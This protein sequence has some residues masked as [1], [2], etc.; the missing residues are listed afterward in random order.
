MILTALLAVLHAHATGQS[1]SLLE[2]GF[3]R[4][5]DSVKPSVYWYWMS[6]NISD[7]GVVKDLEAM[8][9]I[10]IGRAFIGN[11]GMDA[12]E[13]TYGDVKMFS[14]DWWRITQLA[15][16][17]AGRLGIDIGLFNSPGWS[18]S[19]GPWVQPRQA[20]R[21]L[22]P[23]VQR[24]KGPQRF[25]SRLSAP[26][27]HFQDVAV[28]A[29]P[30]EENQVAGAITA[31]INIPDIRHMT[32]GDTAS[33]AFLP[34]GTKA[35]ILDLS[36]P[37]AITA[38]S[39][40]L[41]PARSP[42]SARCELQVLD[43][44]RYRSVQ[45]FDADRSNPQ[46]SVGFMPYGPVAISFPAVSGTAFRL[47]FTGVRGKMGFAEITLGTA[48]K[49]ERYI[50]KQLAKMFQTPLPLWNEYQWAPAP[51]PNAPVTPA[52]KVVDLSRL[53]RPD[54]SLQ[55]NVP[56]GTWDVIRFG[57][58][59]TGVNNSPAVP[60]GT[61][62]EVDKMNK[63]ALAAHFN[64]FVGKIQQ[65]M[66][67][68][69]RSA[70]K[71]VVADSYETGSQNWT[72][73][74]A[75]AF[76]KKYGYDPLPWLPVLTGRIIGSAD[77]SD[78]FLW[79]LRRMVADR[80][81]YDYV[82]G[83]RELSHR[84]GLRVWLEN[85]GHWG[86]PGEF[87]QYGGQS[88]EVGGEF[89]NEGDLGSI[90]NKAAS[91]AAH[92]YGK[93]R[94]AAESFT[95]G[96]RPYQR[97]PALLKKRGDWSF[98]EGVNHTLLHVYIQQP[99][100]ERNPGV[101]AWFG[102]EFNRKNTW[103]YQSKAFIDYIRRCNF[104][105]QQ[106]LPVNDVA[107]FIGEDAPK[108]T[109][110]RD[111]ALPAGY[112]F[113][114]INAEVIQHRLQVKNGRFVLPD[115]M[116]YRL[117]VLPKLATMRPALL[118]R[119]E[120]LVAAGGVVLG[121]APE[122]SP[123]LQ[124]YPAA[125]RE[126]RQLANKLW[127]KVDGRNV[128]WARYGKGIIATGMSVEEIM[129]IIQLGPDF[130][131][132]AAVPVLYTHRSTPPADIYFVTNQA[133]STISFNARFRV[134][135]RQPEWWDAVTG[136]RRPLPEY[137]GNTAV[138]LTLAPFQSGFVVFTEKG[139]RA[140][141]DTVRH[142]AARE[143]DERTG[144]NAAARRSAAREVQ[145]RTGSNAAAPVIPAGT[146]SSNFPEP[147]PLLTVHGPWKLQFGQQAYAW[148]TLQDWS[149]NAAVRN[150]SGTAIYTATF[151]APALPAGARL[152]L[153]LGT[154]KVIAGVKV[155]GKDAGTAWT[156][157]WQV[158]VTGLVYPG[159]N[160]LEIAVTNTWVNRLIGDSQLPAAE[161]TTWTSVNPYTPASVYETSG[162]LGPVTLQA[163]TY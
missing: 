87:L 156:A 92:I 131:A 113:D 90:E 104:I 58:A 83:L 144:S 77:Q 128:K 151:N 24:V 20:M 5:P 82:G 91:S 41:H 129:D 50:E 33:V 88:D 40:V 157:P 108:M 61:G 49:V 36:A 29:V 11:I 66:P 73:G 70:L 32:D 6:D 35:A 96:G 140:A 8:A 112:G 124:N 64:A 46:K 72:D 34:E 26:V 145:E 31:N 59:P 45:Q 9:A 155:N 30:A 147:Q 28:L 56:P 38:R 63:Q 18:Q 7:S 143:M 85:Y 127:G 27:P 126:V 148:D 135:G 154:V 103:F 54:G 109:G 44:G 163:V 99:Y 123:S 37:A 106:G 100:E 115:G 122:R 1:L 3:T 67:A 10:G 74:M 55:W 69:E 62:P 95:A 97:Y 78:R 75:A 15:I 98:T 43:N 86:F 84:H 138:P 146:A 42:F 47:V 80:V 132:P 133:D 142:A 17:T 51:E 93:K 107:Y 22:A 152:Y 110:V 94:V 130:E 118:K 13:T 137:T 68:A 52:A 160:T 116:Q 120:Q 65:S 14:Q 134:S 57:M 4:P 111:P 136:Q 102:T 139:G 153:H 149:R 117:L 162:L 21:Y 23:V 101:N 125:D 119:L 53:L 81:A 158:D 159:A 105:L 16:R 71:Y 19:G 114:Y 141:S 76:K 60:E 48:P 12:A 79:D 25:N 2:A 161:R 39:L 121:P 150:F 89:W